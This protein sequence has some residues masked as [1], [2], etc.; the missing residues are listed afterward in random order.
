MVFNHTAIFP[1]K[2]WPKQI[3]TNGSVMMEGVKMSKSFGNI[4]PLREALAT[5]GA[6][7]IRL[8]VLST[9]E[10]LQD[11][12]FSPTIARSMSERLERLYQLASEVV[13]T[14]GKQRISAKSLTTTD[15]WMQ[16]RL[17]EHIRKATEAMDKLAVRKAI[18]SVLYE[19][20]QD[21]QWYQKRVEAQKNE[22]KRK[23]AIGFIIREVLETQIR[24]LAPVAPHI[25]EELWEMMGG[26][27]F[28]SSS[29]WPK[30][31]ES[32]TDVKAEESEALII[33]VIEDT[34]NIIKATNIKP[35]K[36]CYYVA[37][38]WKWKVYVRTLEMSKRGEVRL[39]D[40]MEEISAEEDQK[41][42]IK[43]AA[44]FASK[45]V[46]EVAM[47]PEKR[48]ENILA[49]KALNEK[50]I[51]ESAEDFLRDRFKAQITVYAE[52]DDERYDPR[53]RAATAVPSRPA[54]YIE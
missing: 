8:S 52:E 13:K 9:A 31:D 54:I 49:L 51:I 38:L 27:G 25:C 33:D 22:A 44:A 53:R 40:L 37:A 5:F 46:K 10:L 41:K 29:S 11:A 32:K 42:K 36:I 34:Q 14:K 19:L 26:K 21:F 48:R 12:E 39:K 47:V 2:L 1:E 17:Q 16:T 20:D 35:K 7:P 50:E 45:I 30:V 3:V 6:D 24:M 23:G 43:E 15:R 18:H 4:I 28:V